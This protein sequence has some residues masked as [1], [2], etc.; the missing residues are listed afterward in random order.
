MLT[1]K[2][3][4]II[5]IATIIALIVL[6][7][8]SWPQIIN[9][10]KQ[11]GGAKWS[12]IFLMIPMQLVNYYS[13]AKLYQTYFKENG[14]ILSM[15][16]MY[17]VALE[18]NFVNHIFPSGGVAGFSYLGLRMRRKGVPV[19]R[20]TLAQAIRFGLTFISFLILLFFGMF[21]LSFGSGKSGGGVALFIGLSI[22]FLTLF[23]MI[24][25]VYVVS[26][27]KRVK[28]FTAFLPKII[29]RFVKTITRKENTFNI[30]RIERLFADLH[31]DYL[32]VAKDWPKLK[33]PLIWALMV[34][35]TEI[36]TAYLAYIA[37]GHLVNPGAVILAYA[38]ASFAG[39]VAI[40][41]GGI[42]VYETLMTAVLASAGVAKALALSATLIY[43]IFC[44]IVF[45]PVG[46]ILYQIAL[47]KG[48][49]EAPI[50][51]QPPINLDP[52]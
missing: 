20:T 49:A 19:S 21:L 18:L 41:P 40:L 28:S 29:N 26:N 22:A 43:R 45:L 30:E 37:L 1:K 13:I 36:S 24:A 8:V 12:V 2:V 14:H 16:S 42:G 5:N 23:G 31:K 52:N 47:R 35:V 38:V 11:I 10:L 9:G 3:K 51:G 4:L 32:I 6:I 7:Y 44:M 34:N 25:G 50:Y 15:K 17:K 39:L 48:A 27:E 46:F 33:V